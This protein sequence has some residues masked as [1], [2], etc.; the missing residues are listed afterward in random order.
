ME[1]RVSSNLYPFIE[2]CITNRLKNLIPNFLLESLT[3]DIKNSL[4][5]AVTEIHVDH[6]HGID[7]NMTNLSNVAYRQYLQQALLNRL[8]KELVDRKLVTFTEV[9]DPRNYT[10]MTRY[11][12]TVLNT[13]EIK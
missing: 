8:V 7:Y 1:S 9:N 2:K 3:E 5:T 10:I 11:S 4:A 6:A 12:I 13:E